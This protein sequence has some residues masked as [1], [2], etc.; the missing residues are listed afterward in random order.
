MH[1][2][3]EKGLLIRNKITFALGAPNY[4]FVYMMF[5][6]FILIFFTDVMK[7]NPVA[8]GRVLLVSRICDAIFDIILGIVID[9]THTKYG[10][11]RPFIF[12]GAIPVAI[13]MILVF[14]I[15]SNSATLNLVWAYVTYTGLSMSLSVLLI[16]TQTLVPRMTTNNHD[17]FILNIIFFVALAICGVIVSSVTM[18]MINTLGGDN[19]ERGYQITAIIMAVLTLSTAWFLCYNTT[20]IK[21]KKTSQ[22]EKISILVLFKSIIKNAPFM[23]MALFGMFFGMLGGLFQGGLAYYATYYLREPTLTPIMTSIL[24]IGILFGS[25]LAYPFLKLTGSKKRIFTVS[26]LVMLIVYAIRYITKD[27]N[28]PVMLILFSIAAIANGFI[29]AFCNLLLMDTMQYGEWKTGIKTEGLVMS[30]YVFSTKIGVGIGGALLGSVLDA[31]GYVANAACQ[32]QKALEGL[33][34]ANIVFP[35]LMMLIMLITMLFYKLDDK[36]I[37]HIT[38]KLNAKKLQGNNSTSVAS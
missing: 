7:V 32:T 34:A 1:N 3:E 22:Q 21:D 25:L 12:C 4:V 2:T 10:K 20:E 33:F 35:I 27:T 38:A 31:S 5:T 26:V 17:R 15:P 18:Y 30:F 8:A 24:W 36:S 9:N 6:M 28:I 37:E 11:V 13:F 14:T 29:S 23:I 19:I 16:S